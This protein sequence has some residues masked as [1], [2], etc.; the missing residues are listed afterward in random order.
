MKNAFKV[1]LLS[2]MFLLIFSCSF[3]DPREP[4][5]PDPGGGIPWQQ[6]YAP[7]T[8]V[9]NLENAME[10]RSV[11]ITMAC[12][13]SS[14]TFI[15]DPADTADFGGSYNFA[16]WD[17]QVEQSVMMNIYSSLPDTGG[18][19]D[20][21]VN[22]VM[23]TVPSLPDPTSYSDSA[24]IWRDYQIVVDGS[25]YCG[26]DNPAQGRVRFMM[27]EDTFGLWSIKTWND[28]RPE[29]YTGD[30]YTW[31]VAKATYR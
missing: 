23:S 5:D 28:Y 18:S 11:P 2:M 17:Y 16:D 15:A 21:L 24:V 4:E 14:Y 6:P 9:V 12:C 25:D 13:D 7:A 27:I 1:C 3:F 26:W 22:V 8:V 20:S 30:N 19:Q 31:G 10:G 29:D